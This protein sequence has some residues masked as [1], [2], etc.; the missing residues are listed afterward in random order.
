MNNK[1]DRL[2]RRLRELPLPSPNPQEI[3]AKVLH[4]I[5]KRPRP[6]RSR[7]IIRPLVGLGAVA[8]AIVAVL[9]LEATP[10][11][12]LHRSEVALQSRDVLLTAAKQTE[13]ASVTPGRFWHTAVRIYSVRAFSLSDSQT[14]TAGDTMTNERWV[15][16]SESDQTWFKISPPGAAHSVLRQADPNDWGARRFGLEG[17]MMTL[18]E[19]RQLPTDVSA[20]RQF[21]LAP[22]PEEYRRSNPVQLNLRLFGQAFELGLAPVKPAVRAVAYRIMA[23]LPGAR[24]LG[25]VK[26]ILGRN[27]VG[28]AISEGAIE[29]QLIIDPATGSVLDLH[30][31]AVKTAAGTPSMRPGPYIPY[32]A[33]L[34]SGWTDAVIPLK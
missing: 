9:L 33:I 28:V 26:D 22:Y 4:G 25:H 34:A 10:R 3:A 1:S 14:S 20:L 24:S 31:V 12:G 6:D 15:A 16:A 27:G 7:Q 21:L 11:V 13:A 18:A 17:R 23:E 2:A 8:A 30:D 29:H 19:L 5:E 32:Q